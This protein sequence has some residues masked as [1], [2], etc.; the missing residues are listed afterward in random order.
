MTTRFFCYLYSAS[1]NLNSYVNNNETAIWNVNYCNTFQPIYLSVVLVCLA[2]SGEGCCFRPPLHFF[3]RC[4]WSGL[5]VF[6]VAL[7][8][9]QEWCH[10][11]WIPRY[12]KVKED[13]DF[14][15]LLLARSQ[16]KEMF[17]HYGHSNSY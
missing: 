3:S 14:R 4:H 9:G 16:Q 7:G 11:T 1:L 8:I 13:G 10:L 12:Y 6:G 2:L 15:P 5:S 17:V